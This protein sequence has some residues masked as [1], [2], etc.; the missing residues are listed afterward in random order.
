MCAHPFSI[1]VEKHSHGRADR[2]VLVRHGAVPV[3]VVVELEPKLGDECLGVV[4]IVLN[5]DSYEL[6]GIPELRM[7]G[8]KQRGFGSARVAPRCPNVDDCRLSQI[9][10]EGGQADSVDRREVRLLEIACYHRPT[11]CDDEQDGCN[12]ALHLKIV[13]LGC[14]YC[15]SMRTDHV[16]IDAQFRGPP[17]SGNGG[18][19]AGIVAEGVD[20]AAEVT[21]RV[22]PPIGRPLTRRSDGMSSQL[23]DGDVLVGEGQIRDRHGNVEL[24]TPV[25]L[26]EA[27]EA[28]DRFSGFDYHI[29]PGCFVCGPE[30]EVGDGLRIFPGWTGPGLVAGVWTPHESF[31]SADG[32][33][34]NRIVWSA[35]DCPS[36]FAI[37]N[38]PMAL[39]G[40]LT[41]RILR[42]PEPGQD[43]VVMGW[44][45]D[46]SGRKHRNGTAIFT[47]EGELL[48][49]SSAIWV[50][51]ADLPL[52]PGE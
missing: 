15:G 8:S 33:V 14:G 3:E 50:E 24:P 26:E 40:R 18:Y 29:F 9:G 47:T 28:A 31:S 42:R 19:A 10:Q 36:Y 11:R 2:P 46:H 12:G 39:L 13:S 52:P 48:A 37:E 25:S 21:L 7:C 45:V 17:R 30:R 4:L 23:F 20:G 49:S 43:L 44:E 35:L 27:S 22:P 1:G 34:D 6:D 5:V 51:V 38:S 41:G 16:I 32:L